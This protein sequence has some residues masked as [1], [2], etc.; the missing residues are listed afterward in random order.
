MLQELHRAHSHPQPPTC[1]L[2]SSMP[3]PCKGYWKPFKATSAIDLSD[4]LIINQQLSGSLSPAF[5][6]HSAETNAPPAIQLHSYRS[7]MR[8]ERTKLRLPPWRGTPGSPRCRMPGLPVVLTGR[9]DMPIAAS[10]GSWDRATAI[11]FWCFDR[12]SEEQSSACKARQDSCDRHAAPRS[13]AANLL[14]EACPCTAVSRTTMPAGC[15]LATPTL[16][17]CF[18]SGRQPSRP[19]W[20]RTW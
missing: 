4:Q 10:T 6:L 2:A 8:G 18:L 14:R 17:T 11:W 1:H 16:L 19:S 3:L 5:F 9:L 7:K 12:K 15:D 13:R 20:P